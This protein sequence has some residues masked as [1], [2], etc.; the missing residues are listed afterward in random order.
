MARQL[1]VDREAIAS[2]AL[3]RVL[4]GLRGQ[5]V[6]AHVLY[7]SRR[8]LSAKVRVF[9]DALAAHL[10]APSGDGTQSVGPTL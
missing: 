9:I 6:D 3:V 2:G 4:P 1:P 7:P 5:S 8:S 10:R